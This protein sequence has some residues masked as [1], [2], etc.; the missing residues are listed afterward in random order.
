[1]IETADRRGYDSVLIFEDDVVFLDDTVAV[2]TAAVSELDGR[3]WDLCYLGASRH[4][5]EFPTLP[6]AQV[7]RRCSPVNGTHAL[8]VHR[9]AFGR[10]L[11]DIPT[12]AADFDSWLTDAVAIDQYFYRA[13][14]AGLLAAVITE[15]RVASQPPLLDSTDHD[16]ALAQ[17]Y[18]I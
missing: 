7:L 9:R 11:A 14:R 10:I 3:D 13:V 8:A 18:T 2:L 4:G 16:A 1:M 6:D 17:R 15:P 12:D 5:Q